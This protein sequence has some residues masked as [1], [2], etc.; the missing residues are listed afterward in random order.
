MSLTDKTD[1]GAMTDQPKFSDRVRS[2]LQNSRE[3]AV[4]LGNEQ[5]EVEHLLL[6]LM[7]APESTAAVLLRDLGCDL[8]ALKE[9]VEDHIQPFPA[10]IH[11]SHLMPL[12]KETERVLRNTYD[13][14]SACGDNVIGT[15]HILLS[16][17]QTEKISRV[18]NDGWSITYEKVRDA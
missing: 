13:E 9:K 14:A 8:P 1:E 11:N 4:R 18:L 17:L 12:T 10:P 5:I 2:V 6:G 16:L 15:K 7:A 3:A